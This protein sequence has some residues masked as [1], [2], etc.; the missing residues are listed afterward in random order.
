MIAALCALVYV[1]YTFTQGSEA[2]RLQWEKNPQWHAS[3]YVPIRIGLLTASPSYREYAMRKHEPF[4]HGSLPL[5]PKRAD[6]RPLNDTV[7]TADR[8]VSHV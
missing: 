1:V 7:P 6:N 2:A 8:G 5:S 3:W 4:S